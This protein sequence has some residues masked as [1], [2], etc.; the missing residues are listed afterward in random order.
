MTTLR[1]LRKKAKQK[2]AD[3]A[4]KLGVTE[5]SVRNWEKARTI[6][7]LN[8]QQ[9]VTLLKLYETT[10]SKLAVAFAETQRQKPKGK[11]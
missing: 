9:Y 6:P 1:D 11:S 5:S 2:V 3:V 7:S 8:P 10:P 4:H